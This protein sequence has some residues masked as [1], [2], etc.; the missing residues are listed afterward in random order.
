MLKRNRG[1]SSASAPAVNTPEGVHAQGIYVDVVAGLRAEN[2]HL[3]TTNR[4]SWLLSLMLGAG[5]VGM[6]LTKKSKPYFLEVDPTTGKVSATNRVAEEFK[7]KDVHTA[8]FIRE[9]INWVFLMN[10]STKSNL[11]KAYGWTKGS[12]TNEL[13]DWALTHDKTAARMAT[14]PGLSREISGLPTVSFNEAGKVAFI[15]VVL[16]ERNNGIES[17]RQRKLVTLEFVLMGSEAPASQ[18]ADNPLGLVIT[19]FTIADQ[20]TQ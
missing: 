10:A 14:V 16:V 4:R 9:W 3:K 1:N 5:L 12:A 8:Y 2:R 7:P 17:R 13:D 18:L 6:A 15:D 19:H 11:T 20:V